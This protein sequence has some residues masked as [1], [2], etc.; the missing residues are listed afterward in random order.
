MRERLDK[1]AKGYDEK[2]ISIYYE[3]EKKTERNDKL[4][5]MGLRFRCEAG[6]IV[7]SSH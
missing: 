4:G 5:I 6:K 2:S 7:E 1:F 3:S